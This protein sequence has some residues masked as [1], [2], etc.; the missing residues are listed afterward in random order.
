MEFI[1]EYS[2]SDK[3]TEFPVSRICPTRS[4]KES[5]CYDSKTHPGVTYTFIVKDTTRKKLKLCCAACTKVKRKI[6][7]LK[8]PIIYMASETT[9]DRDPDGLNHL[10]T[11]DMTELLKKAEEKVQELVEH[12]EDRSGSVLGEG[13]STAYPIEIPQEIS[14]GFPV[15]RITLTRS[16][17]EAYCYDSK[18]HPDVTYIF[19]VKDTAG[20]KIKLV[21]NACMKAKKRVP[22]KVP[23]LY[24]LNNFVFDRDP[25][26]LNHICTIEVSEP[27]DN[28]DLNESGAVESGETK[29]NDTTTESLFDVIE[30]IAFGN[31]NSATEPS[32][33]FANTT[34]VS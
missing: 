30:K 13:P 26:G 10:C 33:S 3:M 25:D 32:T 7:S 11:L 18:T 9:F 31:G 21:C 5:Y 15:S 2:F 27:L 29:A 16:K 28:E 34:E 4:G 20:K 8:A 12:E 17:K 19:T 6:P 14:E 23:N 22:G 24:L 1:Y